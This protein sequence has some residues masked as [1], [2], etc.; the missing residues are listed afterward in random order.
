MPR[1]P[2]RMRAFNSRCLFVLLAAANWLTPFLVRC[3]FVP[4][5]ENVIYARSRSF[6]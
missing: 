3:L 5:R 2:P 6:N 4:C 1:P